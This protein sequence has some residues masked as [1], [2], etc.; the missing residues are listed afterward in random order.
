MFSK[1][2]IDAILNHDTLE[3]ITDETC[4]TN[5]ITGVARFVSQDAIFPDNKPSLKSSQ[6]LTERRKWEAK[7]A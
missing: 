7:T 5:M 6:Y 3:K 2:Q 1:S 4:Q